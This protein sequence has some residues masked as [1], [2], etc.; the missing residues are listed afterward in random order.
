MTTRTVLVRGIFNS[1]GELIRILYRNGG[2]K[3]YFMDCE[4][5]DD[6]SIDEFLLEICPPELPDQSKQV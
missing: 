3:Y 1:Q 2:G 6:K 4:P 5:S